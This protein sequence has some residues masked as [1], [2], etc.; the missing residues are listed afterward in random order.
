MILI[1]WLTRLVTGMRISAGGNINLCLTESLRLGQE[2]RKKKNRWPITLLIQ[3]YVSVVSQ[4][5]ENPVLLFPSSCQQPLDHTVRP[6][7]LSIILCFSL[8]NNV[9]D[10]RPL[11]DTFFLRK[12]MSSF[13]LYYFLHTLSSDFLLLFLHLLIFILFIQSGEGSAFLFLL[14]FYFFLTVSPFSCT[15]HFIRSL[16]F[17]FLSFTLRSKFSF[18]ISGF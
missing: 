9:P 2:V 18:S 17:M 1:G 10:E 11:S 4:R 15:F 13:L 12:V 6:D 5:V 8:S 7:L 3:V 16:S 14:C